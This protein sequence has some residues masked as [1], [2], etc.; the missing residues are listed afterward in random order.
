[1]EEQ[2]KFE[3]I[4][5]FG[6]AGF[7]G[8]HL[9]LE[10]IQT[11]RAKTIYIADIKPFH[12]E[13]L[14]EPLQSTY[15]QGQVIYI[16][17]DVRNKIS[18]SALPKTSDCIINLAAIHKQ[19]GHQDYEYFQTNLLGA[20]NVCDWANQIK[21]SQIIFTS[22]IAVYGGGNL[23]KNEDSLPIPNSPYGIS[24]LVAEKIHLAWQASNDQ[25]SLLIIRPGV[26]FGHGEEGNVS[27]MIKAVLHHYFFFSGNKQTIKAGG[28]VK[29]LTKS[30][31][32][33]LDYQSKHGKKY[34]LANFSMSPAP[35]VG[36]YVKAIQQVSNKSKLVMS[37][38][39]TLLLW[40][41]YGISMVAKMLNIKQ[42]IDPVRVK[43]LVNSNIIL[44]KALVEARYNYS[45]SLVSAL[46]EWK[47]EW[48]SDWK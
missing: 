13:Q 46:A 33:M 21:A 30:M 29:E 48:P 26:I 45:Y 11:G 9:A 2:K 19:P 12:S 42:P 10:L 24:K 32:Y 1:M 22:S 28:Y 31:L 18:D 7:I 44:P 37:V 39:Y 27:R 36:Q 8:Q 40:A 14:A 3:N 43:K 17:I 5:I 4:V 16:N 35:T 23:E 6:G 38:P 25:N 41:S 47:K 15:N 20:E 34:I